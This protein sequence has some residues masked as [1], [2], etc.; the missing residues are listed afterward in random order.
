MRRSWLIGGIAAVVV[1]VVLLAY[2]W[3]GGGRVP[4]HQISLPLPLPESAR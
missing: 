1:V 2:A 4:V 3:I